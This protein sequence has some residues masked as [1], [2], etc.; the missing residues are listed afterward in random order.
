MI[1]PAQNLA[2]N[3]RHLMVKRYREY[4]EACE[5][6]DA[7]SKAYSTQPLRTWETRWSREYLK[8]KDADRDAAAKKAD[9]KRKDVIMLAAAIKALESERP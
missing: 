1:T 8:G 4:E 6:F 5:E 9:W 7:I 3:L 2:S